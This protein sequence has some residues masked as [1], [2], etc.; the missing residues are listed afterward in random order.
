M[1]VRRCRTSMSQITTPS[2]RCSREMISALSL[3]WIPDQALCRGSAPGFVHTLQM[4]NFLSV[5]G[6]LENVGVVPVEAALEFDDRGATGRE[7]HG[8][9]VAVGFAGRLPVVD[10]L[11][12]LHVV[13][14]MLNER[15][16][17]AHRCGHLAA[18]PLDSAP[19]KAAAV[20]LALVEAVFAERVRLRF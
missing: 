18:D 17:L 13:E 19:E 4:M 5:C 15:S 11:A 14:N 20:E 8:V 6:P 7:I 9:V 10:E 1:A 12:V 2:T 16:F 3:V